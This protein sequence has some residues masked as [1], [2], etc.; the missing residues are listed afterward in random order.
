MPAWD[1]RGMARAVTNFAGSCTRRTRARWWWTSTRPSWPPSRRRA[2]AARRIRSRRGARLRQRCIAKRKKSVVLTR[3]RPD[4][5]SDAATRPREDPAKPL[6][7]LSGAGG[8]TAVLDFVGSGPTFKLVRGHGRA[9]AAAFCSVA[10]CSFGKADAGG[11][12]P[13]RACGQALDTVQRGGRVVVTGLFGGTANVA[14]STIPSKPVSIHGVFVG[15]VNE[16]RSALALQPDR[17]SHRARLLTPCFFGGGWGRRR[18]LQRADGPIGPVSAAD[19]A[20]RG[21]ATGARVCGTP[22]PARRPHRRPSSARHDPRGATQL[23]VSRAKR[24]R[25]GAGPLYGFVGVYVGRTPGEAH[26]GI[27][28]RAR[29]LGAVQEKACILR[30]YLELKR[31]KSAGALHEEGF[32]PP[33]CRVGDEAKT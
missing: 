25:A 19:A 6:R 1:P 14:V 4:A 26:P 27:H 15:T 3:A 18:D 30:S 8:Y 12:A 33:A 5:H 10:N 13:H 22:R 31:T 29:P 17:R 9:G 32:S 24:M 11:G 21:A 16:F 7:Q 2:C 23:V 20:D 28:G